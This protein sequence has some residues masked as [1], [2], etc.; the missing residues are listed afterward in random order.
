MGGRAFDNVQPVPSSKVN[1]LAD[2]GL[3][4][5][6][7]P[8]WAFLGS[9]GKKKLS[10]DVDIAVS[11]NNLSYDTMVE[12]LAAKLGA[13]NVN[14]HGRNLKQVY[15]RM[16]AL[17]G[18]G[19]YQVDFM[20][21]YVPLLEFTHWSP[22]PQSSNYT[23]SHRTELIKAAAKVI[24]PFQAFVGGRMIARIGYTLYHDRG[25]VFSTRWCPPRKDG[26][27]YTS[28][29]VELTVDAHDQFKE[30]FPEVNVAWSATTTQPDRICMEI[31]GHSNVKQLNSYELVAANILMS[32]P[33]EK[34]RELIW[35][36][37]TQRLDEIK[38]PH[39][40]RFI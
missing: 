38:L 4:I 25:L 2:A 17:D 31:F 5:L 21:G 6:G 40:V 26:K 23:G 35:E 12:R 27:G 32:P 30:H 11:D 10:G 1:E 18:S 19:P 29:M 33:L 20:L 9:T 16:W 8:W 15:T 24:S 34:E 13:E 39:P 37:Y 14:T 28:K 22:D 3:R 7:N 36:L